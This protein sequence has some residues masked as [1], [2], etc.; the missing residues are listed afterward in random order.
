M[1]LYKDCSSLGVNS[2]LETDFIWVT[3]MKQILNVLG[4]TSIDFDVSNT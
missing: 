3:Y 2:K 4:F 1:T